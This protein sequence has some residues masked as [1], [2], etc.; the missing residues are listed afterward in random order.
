MTLRTVCAA[1][2]LGATLLLA[3]D[4]GAWPFH[5]HTELTYASLKAMGTRDHW[6]Q[7]R[8]VEALQAAWKLARGALASSSK[9]KLCDTLYA[10]DAGRRDQRGHG[11]PVPNDL[12]WMIHENADNDTCI[13]F[14]PLPALAADHSCDPDDLW[15]A[16]EQADWLKDV[17]SQAVKMYG[18]VAEAK[19]DPVRLAGLSRDQDIALWLVDDAYLE[20]AEANSA[21][22]Q[23]LRS[24]DQLG[25]FLADALA[26]G[27]P[28]NAVALWVSFHGAALEQAELGVR[29]APACE[30]TGAKDVDGC[31]L[32]RATLWNAFLLEAFALHYLED[33]F[34]AGH[35]V[36]S[37]GGRSESKGTH[38]YY[39][40]YGL[41][42]TTWQGDSYAAHGDFYMT[43]EDVRRV[44]AAGSLSLAQLG[45]I[46]LPLLERKD[47]PAGKLPTLSAH[48]EEQLAE[49]RGAAPRNELDVC[50]E[51]VVPAGLAPLANARFV[52]DV[53]A[54]W[55]KPGRR[56]PPMPRV[57]AEL[58][59]FMGPAVAIDRGYLVPTNALQS[60]IDEELR[61]RVGLQLGYATDGVLS[62]GRYGRFFLAPTL[63]GAYNPVTSDTA[64]AI[65]L[66]LHSPFAILPGDAILSVPLLL[67]GHPWM[68]MQAGRGSV[69]RGIERPCAL[70]QKVTIQLVAGREVTLL[71]YFQRGTGEDAVPARYEMLLPGAHLAFANEWGSSVALQ[72]GIDLG[73]Q[74]ATYGHGLPAYHGFYFSWVSGAR[75]YP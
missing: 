65:G 8:H 31:A 68:A 75:W 23:P 17:L 61:F 15:H 5:E 16:L 11:G 64:I 66:E 25:S 13:S 19:D 1:C 59:F 2:A 10:G 20:R 27:A 55:P 70:S 62:Q 41:D 51:T 21:H 14:L 29:L 32:A 37:W 60:P 46:L 48:A 40:R 22:F 69:W 53:V 18:S 26:A 74:F 50:R 73:Y 72:S 9:T 3:A 54:L 24:T 52:Q 43:D 42:A 28:L 39:C 57:P 6:S 35:V 30:A 33:A 56:S 34:A 38:D 58:G 12:G 7:D 71:R 47:T 36:G 4:S 45:E 67:S 44:T 49:L 63:A